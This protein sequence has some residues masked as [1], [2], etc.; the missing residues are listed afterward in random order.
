M[1]KCKTLQLIQPAAATLRWLAVAILMGSSAQAASAQ[2]VCVE[3]SRSVDLTRENLI[4]ASTDVRAYE[5]RAVGAGA[6]QIRAEFHRLSDVAASLIANG[7]SS[8]LLKRA[9]GSPKLIESDVLKTYVDLLKR[10]GVTQELQDRADQWHV[11]ADLTIAAPKGKSTPDVPD[12][13]STRT[14]RT[15]VGIY[16]Q[17]YAPAYPAARE[18]SA[19]RNKTVPAD[20]KYFYSASCLERADGGV[21]ESAC[22]KYDTRRFSMHFWRGM[23]LGDVTNYSTNLQAF[24]RMFRNVSGRAIEPG[25]RINET[26]PSDLKLVQHLAGDIWPDDFVILTATKQHEHGRGGGAD[27]EIADWSAGYWPRKILVDA[28]LIENVSNQSIT[29]GAL[30]GNR[31]A[32]PRLR[33]AASQPFTATAAKAV[34]MSETIAPGERLIVFT[35]ITFVP[36]DTFFMDILV[37]GQKSGEIRNRVGANGFQEGGAGHG[38]PAF[39]NYAFGPELTVSGF[40]LDGKSV[41]LS[42]KPS[43]NFNDMV[44]SRVTG[45]CP[46]LLSWD[47]KQHQWIE[48]GKILDQSP[49]EELEYSELRTFA[50]F[51]G[52]FRIEER[53]PEAA[54]IRR[55]VLTVTLHDGRSITLE[56][57]G[58]RQRS[59]DGHYLP[60]LFGE[61]VDIEF[62]LP[63]GTPE[64]AVKES[65]LTV[66]GYYVR[67][68]RALSKID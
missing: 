18:V 63:E 46:Y 41:A 54:Y 28:V 33:V 57:K 62:V 48:H 25:D 16:S 19:L 52:R 38:V 23:R 9:V 2:A 39:K 49:R 47:N 26:V 24:N 35:K 60:I 21:G 6:P 1:R 58:E 27:A 13:L 44:V 61:G 17:G 37:D 42:G 40:I 32:T 50:G 30:L 11:Q 68:S 36:N 4:P 31:I 14:I 7:Q 43:A 65:R 8:E 59:G 20:T 45:S 55:A 3:T 53:E 66:T 5:C 51:R 64:E 12:S 15:I 34:D 56:P 22:R 29:V 10:F 67:Y